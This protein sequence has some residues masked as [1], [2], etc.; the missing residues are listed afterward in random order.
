MDPLV[1]NILAAQSTFSVIICGGRGFRLQ[2]RGVKSF[3]SH[4]QAKRKADPRSFAAYQ[5]L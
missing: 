5:C 1:G 2:L 4:L 3:G